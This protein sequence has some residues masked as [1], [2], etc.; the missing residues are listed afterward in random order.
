[1][2]QGINETDNALVEEMAEDLG[3][4]RIKTKLNQGSTGFRGGD[5]KNRWQLIAGAA[6]LICIILIFIIIG[7]SGGIDEKDFKD[8]I[9]KIEKLEQKTGKIEKNVETLF[10]VKSRLDRFEK[11]YTKTDRSVRALR[12]Q[13]NRLSRKM[14]RTATSS[15]RSTSTQKKSANTKK[16]YYTV[17]K[18]DTLFSISKKLGTSVTE[19][20][21]ANKFS[22]NQVIN[23]GQKIIIP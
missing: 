18:G 20:R 4:S 21:R 15:S 6:I 13:L 2:S 14:N 8:L 10:E 17:K 11:S 1:M 3:N 23:T 5:Q 7:S 9:A 12:E 16:K 22:K 19:I